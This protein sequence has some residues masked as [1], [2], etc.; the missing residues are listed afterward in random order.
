MQLIQGL[1]KILRILYS[2][3]ITNAEVREVCNVND[4]W[5]S[6]TAVLLMKTITVQLLLQFASLHQTGNDRKEDW[7][8]SETTEHWS[9][10]RVEESSLSRTLAFDCGHCLN[11]RRVC[12]EKRESCDWCELSALWNMAELRWF[13]KHRSSWQFMIKQLNLHWVVGCWC[14]YLSGTRCRL[15]YG[16]ADATA[17]HFLLL[18]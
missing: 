18:Q 11:P 9:F 5:D 13:R 15:A 8:G 17:T 12:H 2:H 14:G 1:C 3:H 7:I 16:P 4:T 10:L 6:W